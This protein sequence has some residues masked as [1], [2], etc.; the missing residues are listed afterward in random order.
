[1]LGIENSN[2]EFDEM[3]AAINQVYLKGKISSG[4]II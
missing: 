1:M 3:K 2:R 4:F